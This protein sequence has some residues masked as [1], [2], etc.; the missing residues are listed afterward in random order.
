MI[1]RAS[2]TRWP[3][4]SGVDHR[5]WYRNTVSD[6]LEGPRTSAEVADV[7]ADMIC[8]CPGWFAVSA[9]APSARAPFQFGKCVKGRHFTCLGTRKCSPL[10]PP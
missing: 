10:L 6:V 4:E 5:K 7:S 2:H 3:S 8:C 1:S 9:V